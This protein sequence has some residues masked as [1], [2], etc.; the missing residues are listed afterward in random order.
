MD[1]NKPDPQR[2]DTKRKQEV[3]PFILAFGESATGDIQPVHDIA[4]LAAESKEIAELARFAEE[5]TKQE[6]VFFTRS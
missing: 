1:K 3:F 2:T 4:S 5:S 6:M